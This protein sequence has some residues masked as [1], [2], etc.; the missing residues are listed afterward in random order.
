MSCVLAFCF[1]LV[2][3]VFLCRLLLAIGVVVFVD[4]IDVRTENMCVLVTA[5]EFQVRGCMDVP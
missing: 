3:I 4:K 5:Q 2:F 1:R